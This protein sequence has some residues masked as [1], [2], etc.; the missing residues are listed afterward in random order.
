MAFQDVL[1]STPEP[2]PVLIDCTLG[3]GGHALA[4]LQ[5]YTHLR[6]IGIDQDKQ[7][8]QQAL[9][10]LAPYSDRLCF[11]HGNF[12]T[13]LPTFLEDRTICI[14]GVLADLGV[15]SL[16]LES[17][18]RGFGFNASTLDMRMDTGNCLDAY[19]VINH[20]SCYELERVLQAGEIKESK[21]IAHLIVQRRHQAPFKTARD[22]SA[23][24]STHLRRTK[25]HPATLVFQ[26]IRMEVNAEMQNLRTLLACAKK[27][28]NALLAIISF[29]SLED[30]QVKHAF[31][32][33]AKSYGVL[34]TK[35]PI[36]PSVGE[37]NSNPRSRSAKMRVFYFQGC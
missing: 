11:F 31:R 21:K 30:R 35:K 26:A 3:L 24:L 2:R 16:Q 36:T 5:T 18:D 12:A 17:M 28:K 19:K 22:L 27:L 13:L 14:K 29:H 37:L 23:F 1:R 6:I 7:A 9:E 32:D 15:S 4:L 33:Y 25:H 10:R 8:S 20:Y 34:L